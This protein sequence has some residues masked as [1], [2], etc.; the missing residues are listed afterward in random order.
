MSGTDGYWLLIGFLM[1]GVVIGCIP[2]IVPLLIAPRY[3]GADTESVYECGVDTIGSA[4]TRFSVSYYVFALIFVAFEV[5]V[6]YLFPVAL[7]YDNGF[8]FRDL[9]EV[10]MFLMILS[11]ALVYAWRKGVFKWK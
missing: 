3:K 10:S 6:L 2:L 8:A 7:V 5:D 9:I 4:W 1:M 11:L